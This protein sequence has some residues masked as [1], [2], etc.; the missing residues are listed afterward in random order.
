[1]ETHELDDRMESFFLAETTKYLY[2]LFDENNFIHSSDGASFIFSEDEDD[3]NYK[4]R[5]CYVG[6]SGYIF[7]T[8]AHP[9]DIAS[10]HCC[11]HKHKSSNI[12]SNRTLRGKDGCKRRPFHQKMFGLGVY[13]EDKDIFQNYPKANT[14]SEL[15]Q[16]TKTCSKSEK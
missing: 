10:L 8:E 6:S 5:N 15:S 4:E 13:T 1:M 14:H 9:I 2:L 7:N 16:Q 11:K 3:Y 12:Y